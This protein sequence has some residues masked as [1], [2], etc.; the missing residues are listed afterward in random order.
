MG[1]TLKCYEL[2]WINSG[3]KTVVVWP[4]TSNPTNN[5]NKIKETCGGTVGELRMNPVPT[6]DAVEKTYQE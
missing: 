4:P 1:T 3:N 6:L 2:F 5:P